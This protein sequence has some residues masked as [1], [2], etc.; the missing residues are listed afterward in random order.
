MFDNPSCGCCYDLEDSRADGIRFVENDTDGDWWE[1]VERGNTVQIGH[2][3]YPN[4][5]V[6]MDPDEL[7]TINQIKQ[8]RVD[9]R[10]SEERE[11]ALK[12]TIERKGYDYEKVR[13][14]LP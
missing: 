12:E 13:K 10:V 2:F 7:R 11:Q 9:E 8:R 5:T 4:N 14:L 3:G 1:H 6:I